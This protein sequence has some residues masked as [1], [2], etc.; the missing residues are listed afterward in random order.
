MKIALFLLFATVAV[1]QFRTDNLQYAGS[2]LPPKHI[3][4]TFDDGVSGTAPST[5]ANQTQNIAQLLH[6]MGIVATFFQVGCHFNVLPAVGSDPL[7]SACMNGDMHPLAMDQ[8]L[9]SSGHIIGNHTWYHIPLTMIENDPARV[10]KNVKLAQQLL[11]QFQPDGLK[12]FRAPGLAFDPV[13]A[14]IL[15]ADPAIGKLIGP[16]GMDIDATLVFNG[17]Q[18]NGDAGWFAAGMSAEECADAYFVQVQQQCAGQGCVILIHDRT[19]ME[20]VTDW[21]YR[22]TKRLLQLMGSDY[23]AVPTDAIPGILGNTR[24][25]ATK[26]WTAEFGTGDGAGPVVLGDIAGVKKAAAC[27]V[28]GDGQ[29]WCA[30]P[31]AAADGSPALQLASPWLA[32][33]DPEWSSFGSRFWLADMDGDGNDDL[34]YATSQGFWVAASNGHSG[35]GQPQLRSAA[36]SAAHGWDVRALQDGVRF[37]NFFERGP[38]PKD[39]LVATASGV[40]VAKNYGANFGQPM[41]W[42]SYVAAPADLVTLQARDLNGDGLDDVLIRDSALGQML[43]FTVASSGFGGGSFHAPQSWMTFAGQTNRNGWNDP[44]NGATIR[45]IHVGSPV[46]SAVGSKVVLTAAAATGV[47][48]T[49]IA[50][51][52]FNS[53]WRHLC[54]TC[55]TNLPNWHTER[56]AAAIAWADLDGAGSDWAVFT[57]PT[58]LEI[59]PGGVQ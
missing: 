7:S 57:R 28:R 13:V 18:F 10:L 3:V 47:I 51:S 11:D 42:S 41:L 30:L 17:L 1:A 40:Y 22:V 55:Y 21:G 34:I 59:A 20:I 49:N 9:L 4:I 31:G 6:D 37:G 15:N 29:V 46:G 32:I 25:G 16:V 8:Q 58:G 2:D 24:L 48:Y 23:T 45:L 36:F 19:E 52:A 26:L 53:G 14:S 44:N 12:L 35:F 39:L 38:G 33:T 5:G 56:Q 27:K 54:N 50:A 43:V